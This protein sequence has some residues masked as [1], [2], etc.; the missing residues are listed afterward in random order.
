MWKKIIVLAFIVGLILVSGD[1]D[2]SNTELAPSPNTLSCISCYTAYAN[3]DDDN[4]DDNDD[5][6]CPPGSQG[7]QGEQGPQGPK[8]KPGELPSDIKVWLVSDREQFNLGDL[9]IYTLILLNTAKGPIRNIQLE[10]EMPKGVVIVKVEKYSLRQNILNIDWTKKSLSGIITDLKVGEKVNIFIYANVESILPSY[11]A[12][13]VA[14][15]EEKTKRSDNAF[16]KVIDDPTI[17]T[18]LK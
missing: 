17:T 10:L 12:Q 7:P 5:C 1:Y 2:R 3:D 4:D 16:T 11:I 18:A 13:A 15:F 9:P 14:I 6:T 8:G